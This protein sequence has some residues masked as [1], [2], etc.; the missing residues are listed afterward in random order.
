VPF[1]QH[2]RL[3]F[4]SAHT[5]QSFRGLIEL[6]IPSGPRGKDA[7]AGCQGLGQTLSGSRLNS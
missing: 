7:V 1:T 2:S 6:C 5:R 4:T 3:K